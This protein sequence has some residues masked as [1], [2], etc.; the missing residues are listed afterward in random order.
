MSL[1]IIPIFLIG[2]FWSAALQGQDATAIVKKLDANLAKVKDKQ[3]DVEMTM[4]NLKSGK[5]KLKKAVLYQKG[6]DKKL[7]RYT[8]PESDA[9]IASLTLPNNEVY[10]Y[11]P[12]FKKPKKITNIAESNAFNKSDFS[13]SDMATS[14]YL[15]DYSLTLMDPDGTAHKVLLSPKDENT[16]YTK[17]VLYINKTNSILEKVEYYDTGGM[18]KFATY[19]QI[20]VQGIWVPDEVSMENV[21]K[22]SKTTLKMSNIKINQGLDDGIFTVEMLSE[23]PK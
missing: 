23:E 7:F 20:K 22:Q 14:G 16:P 11:L 9:G 3:V 5:Q 21:K 8:Y 19:H 2:L 1:K 18:E 10:L 13:I 4:T 12:M 17:L 15:K 6:E